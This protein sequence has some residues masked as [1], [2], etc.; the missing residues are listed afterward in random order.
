MQTL[1]R[2]RGACGASTRGLPS[3]TVGKASIASHRSRP[4]TASALPAL[5][6]AV[7]HSG[8]AVTASLYSVAS[9]CYGFGSCPSELTPVAEFTP[10]ASAALTLA[11]EAVAASTSAVPAIADAGISMAQVS[12]GLSGLIAASPVLQL[13]T[14][15]VASLIGMSP[16]PE[17]VARLSAIYYLLLTKPGPLVS[18]LDFYVVGKVF[19]KMSSLD[20]RDYALREKL[21]GGNF[22]TAY[23]AIKIKTGET[24]GA[25]QLL[26]GD[27]KKRRVVLKRVNMDRSE[28][29]DSF[30]QSGTMAKGASETGKVEAYMCD[31]ISRSPLVAACCAR[32]IGNFTPNATLGNFAK[33]SQWLVWK[34]ESDCTLGDALDG[35]LG[36]FPL[37][38]EAYVMG[39]K[40]GE[41]DSGTGSKKRSPYGNGKTNSSRANKQQASGSESTV[42]RENA[43][44]KS[45]F[46]QVLVGLSRLHSIGIVHRDVKPENLLITGDGSVKIIDFGAAVDMSTGINF[47]P[48]FGM[49]D[50]R[51][52]PPEE[53][54]MPKS[55]PR[56]PAPAL[57]A[58]LAPFAWLYG[59]PD[60]FDSYSAGVLL[61]QMSVPGLRRGTA[62]RL[63][64]AELA[65]SDF[66][67][68]VWRDSRGRSQDFTLL[69]RNNGAGFDLAR[70]LICKR[71]GPFNRGRL[72]VGGALLHRYFLPE[73]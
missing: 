66:D 30:L 9:E 17:G 29:R 45:L 52:S 15:D 39:G 7:V 4:T 71:S 49:L 69:D 37:D 32:F 19:S 44:V 53:L 67:L 10:V 48:L 59:A 16:T 5:V 20:F 41:S 18:L 31:K 3:L 25:R 27:Q 11:T 70:K 42:K 55:F 60:L 72:S 12:A 56:A 22:G 62:M 28:N 65:Q 51:Y 61:V 40:G 58:L 13:L 36:E 2:A 35:Q 38:V 47:N 63:F 73:F 46:K 34:F 24:I 57:A 33:G 43:V 54:V 21:G 50:P 8:A 23:E 1:D 6:E 68:K 14:G 26:N 64:N